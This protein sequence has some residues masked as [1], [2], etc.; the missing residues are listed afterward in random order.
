M[1]LFKRLFIFIALFFCTAKGFAQLE[2]IRS[3]DAQALAQ[4]LVGSGVSISNV[5]LSGS[6]LSTAFFR[7][8]GGTQL[9]ID[10][11][12]VL[13]TGRV[14]TAG[15]FPG[16]DGPQASTA[17][18][19]IN[20]LGDIQL[21]Q[22]V[23]NQRTND[24]V[25]LEFDFVPL[26]D[27]VRFNY[28]FSSEE[29][30]EYNCSNYNDVFAFF[31]SGPG[32]TG[33]NNIALVPG[34]DIPVAINSINNGI[35]GTSGIGSCNAMGA[36]SPFVQF[37]VNNS[38]NAHF[39][40]NGHT[41]VLTAKSKVEPCQVYHLKIAIADAFDRIFDSG[42]FLEAESL[43]SD[44]ISIDGTTP[45]VG[46]KPYLVEG[47][48]SGKGFNV[49]RPR[50]LPE[51]QTVNLLITGTAT[52]GVDV[53]TIPS[54]AV[55]PAGDSIVFVSIEPI[56]DNV[57]EGIEILKIYLSNSCA[58]ANF[59]FDSLEVQLRDFDTLALSPAGRVSICGDNTV[60]LSA[61][62]GLVSYQWSPGAG[63]NST[64][65]A[66][67]VADP[68]GLTTYTC[69]AFRG[70]SCWAKDSVTVAKKTLG[71][72][73]KQ[74]INCRNGLTGEIRVS[75]GWVWQAPVQYSI[76]NGS[77][78]IDS[79]FQNL[80]AGNY[81]VKIKDA[82]GCVDSISLSLVQL[83]PDLVF[84]DQVTSASCNGSNGKIELTASGG[85]LPYTYSAGGVSYGPAN[86]LTVNSGNTT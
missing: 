82:T 70:G 46:G 85:N 23:N 60:Q 28:V 63:L 81:V 42:V 17:S 27:T 45:R 49:L 74:D 11:G 71:L 30:P 38:G 59:Y 32:I 31:I 54:T 36:G 41:V 67:P 55:I 7:N 84:I 65:I 75:G 6:N 53:Q 15:G 58:A 5:T 64:T 16:I 14:Q 50:K 73:S 4:K 47:C 10:S 39:S 13:S 2:I 18:S 25:I 83:Y 76:N 48:H 37:Y 3:S 69:T 80:A 62:A 66:N 33:A 12:I 22:L 26:G 9:G 29:Y 20:T 51:P 86:I 72:I 43:K 44:P 79:N 24:A 52:N 40:H 56:I 78:G 77:Y 35:P 68:P 19:S 34:T 8:L 1:L 61:T 57:S 21:S